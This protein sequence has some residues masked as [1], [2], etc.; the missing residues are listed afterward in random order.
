MPSGTNRSGCCCHHSSYIQ[1]LYA[2]VTA[3]PSSGSF[4][5]EYTGAHLVEAE[6]L[7]PV[8]ARAPAGDRVHPGLVV[9]VALELPDLVPE[10]VHHHLRG[11]RLELGREAA[12]EHVGRL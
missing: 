7:E 6:G 12:L 1:S 8:A 3:W 2:R 11:A 10:V 5:V 4:A 9:R